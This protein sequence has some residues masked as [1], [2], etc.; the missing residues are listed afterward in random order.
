MIVLHEVAWQASSSESLEIESFDEEPT[1]VASQVKFDEKQAIEV[2]V[3]DL[4]LRTR[5]AFLRWG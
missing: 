1:G 5:L 4:H 3:G 2:E